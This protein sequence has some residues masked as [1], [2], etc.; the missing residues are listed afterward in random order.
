MKVI[1]DKVIKE[2]NDE[3]LLAD[4]ICAGWSKVEDRK[5]SRFERL[6]RLERDDK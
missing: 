2:I 1:K 4:Y 5:P 6:E 3:A